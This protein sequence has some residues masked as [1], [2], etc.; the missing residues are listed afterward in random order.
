MDRRRSGFEAAPLFDPRPHQPERAK[1]RQRDEFICIASEAEGDPL[2]S[3]VE[4][5]ARRVEGAQKAD[6]GAEREGK[7]L[8][9]R[10]ARRVDGSRVGNHERPQKTFR[11]Q[12]KRCADKGLEM[13]GPVGGK[14]SKG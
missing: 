6:G 4:R 1:F 9:G 8:A 11:S 10:A 2:A 7:L 12:C 5:H 13:R 14:G 3:L